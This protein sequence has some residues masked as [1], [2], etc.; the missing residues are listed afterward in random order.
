[1]HSPTIYLEFIRI[2]TILI[3]K[4]GNLLYGKHEEL[5]KNYTLFIKP[6]STPLL[7][8]L[9]ASTP[10][11]S[12]TKSEL[13]TPK[14]ASIWGGD[15]S[16]KKKSSYRNNYYQEL[17]SNPLEASSSSKFNVDSQNYFGS[18]RKSNN[19]I[20]D[21]LRVIN[22]NQAEKPYQSNS[23]LIPFTKKQFYFIFYLPRYLQT[24]GFPEK[25]N[26]DDSSEFNNFQPSSVSYEKTKK[27]AHDLISSTDAAHTIAN[28]NDTWFIPVIVKDDKFY[29]LV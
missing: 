23:K 15:S 19:I 24:I 16:K 9:M 28:H 18:S 25:L 12:A 20:K 21:K 1:M 11:E 17:F 3:S 2:A 22:E 5:K 13:P 6:N 4:L 10:G 8:S 27:K 26:R 29:S 7:D 14:P